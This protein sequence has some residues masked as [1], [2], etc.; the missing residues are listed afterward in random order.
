MAEAP[1]SPPPFGDEWKRVLVVVNVF[2]WVTVVALDIHLL[3]FEF[4]DPGTQVHVLQIAA[5]ASV[6]A[7]AVTVAF[8]TLMHYC[9]ESEDPTP[10]ARSRALG[11]PASCR[12]RRWD[13]TSS[14]IPRLLV[15]CTI[16][17]ILLE[18]ASLPFSSGDGKEARTLPPFATS[19]IAGGLRATTGFS[20]VLL[21]TIVI[22]SPH[23]NSGSEM[24]QILVAQICLK[25]F[26]AAMAMANQ[27]YPQFSNSVQGAP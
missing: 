19:L 2:V 6:S 18:A 7:A 26:G 10:T 1:Y 22:H 17:A 5:L 24:L 12:Y 15:W 25:T 13:G 11:L 3:A 27:R 8:F 14:D 20:Y 16:E 21:L 23:M 9:S 4:N